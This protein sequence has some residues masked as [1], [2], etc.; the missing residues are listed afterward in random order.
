M[1]K[2]YNREGFWYS[3]QEPQYPKP[4]PGQLDNS[5][6]IKIF[7]LIKRKEK[8]AVRTKQKGFSVSRIDG[9]TNVGSSTFTHGKWMWPEGFAEHYVLVH[10]VKPSKEFLQYIGYKEPETD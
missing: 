8:M 5:Q 10:K 4:V 3:K 6:A 2:E 9:K 1:E 7:D